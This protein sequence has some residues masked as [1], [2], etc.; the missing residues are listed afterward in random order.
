MEKGAPI[1]DESLTLKDLNLG[2]PGQRRDILIS[3][4]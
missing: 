2:P 1:A 4:V 3:T